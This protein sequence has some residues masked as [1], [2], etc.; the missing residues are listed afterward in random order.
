[1]SADG[2][3]EYGVY[4]VFVQKSH[5]DHHVHVGSLMAPS[6]DL[7]MQLARENFLRRDSAVNLWIVPR[8]YIY[9]TPYS[10]DFFAREMDRKY[11]EVGGYTENGRLWRLFKEKTLTMEE[12]VS[13]IEET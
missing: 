4:E 9:T 3:V 12:I 2:K 7:A 5:A 1:M 8:E 10:S 13:H 6:P 11:R